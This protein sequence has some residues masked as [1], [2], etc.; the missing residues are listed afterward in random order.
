METRI[1]IE[2]GQTR[3]LEITYWPNNLITSEHIKDY[4]NNYLLEAGRSVTFYREINGGNPI[5]IENID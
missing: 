4:Y 5:V 1:L 2:D 3:V